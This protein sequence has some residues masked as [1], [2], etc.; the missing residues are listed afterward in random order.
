MRH[1]ALTAVLASYAATLSAAD[2]EGGQQN[3]QRLF[4][5]MEANLEKA[6]ALHLSFDGR[7][8]TQSP[9]F[10]GW[11]LKGTVAVMGK[12][13]RSE[14]SGGKPGN[15]P[16]KALT[17]SDGTRVVTNRGSDRKTRPAS[18]VGVS[19]LLTVVSRPGF[20]MLI[21]P[22]P[23]EPFVNPDVDFKEGFPVSGF[24]LGPKEQVG[25]R[26]T[27]RV[28]YTLGVKGNDGAFAAS[29]WIDLKAGLPVKR[30]VGEGGETVW[31]SE[32]YEVG[33][34]GKLDA[35]MFELPK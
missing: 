24:K 34:G 2:R 17:V 5:Q 4:Q 26:E 19:N 23:P 31:Y 14:I 16:F 30:R 25:G 11:K 20:M 3:A 1:I 33:L 13:Y 8:E 18:K 29:V 27:Q 6:E 7:F 28:D 10:Q 32:T 12:R 21:T 15:D 35:K 22:L 9:P